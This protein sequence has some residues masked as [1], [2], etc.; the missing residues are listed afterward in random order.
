MLEIRTLGFVILSSA[1]VTIGW[2]FVSDGG[3]MESIG[4]YTI[5]SRLVGSKTC[6]E[7]LRGGVSVEEIWEVESK[8]DE[9]NEVEVEGRLRVNS[10]W[11]YPTSR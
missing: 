7:E 2:M 10:C 6:Y 8:I 1:I 5:N 11:V 9:W 4:N 3:S